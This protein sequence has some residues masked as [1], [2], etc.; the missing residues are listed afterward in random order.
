MLSS[1]P[2]SS[3]DG[4]LFDKNLCGSNVLTQNPRHH[5]FSEVAVTPFRSSMP[6]ND[7][8]SRGT[9]IMILVIIL[10]IIGAGVYA[11][12][13]KSGE[14]TPASAEA[15]TKVGVVFFLVLRAYF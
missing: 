11:W 7:K 2:S 5:P 4:F 15:P 1:R 8:A 10:L 14:A 3:E 9:T 13:R 12:Y 6:E